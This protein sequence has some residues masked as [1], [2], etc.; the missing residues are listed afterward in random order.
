M[1][2][3]IR[4]LALQDVPLSETLVLRGMVC[5]ILSWMWAHH[6]GLSLRPRSPRTQIFRAAL[7]GLALT[8]FSLSYDWLTASTVAVLSNI[9]VPMLIVLGPVVG[10]TASRKLRGFAALSILFLVWY[11][12]GLEVQKDLWWGLGSLGL[13]SVLLCF[14]FVFIKKSMTEENEA[15]TVWVPALALIAY[16]LIER[17]V[18]AGSPS[19]GSWQG[20]SL[21][22]G[23]LSG[24]GMFGAY[25]ATMRLYEVT[26]LAS[27]EFPT[28]LSSIVIQPL[29]FFLLHEPMQ[30]T[31]LVSS[32]GFVLFT[33]WIVRQQALPATRSLDLPR[34][35]QTLD[36][37]CGAACFESMFRFLKGSSP[38][39][40]FFARELKSL[41]LGYTPPENI[42]ELAR[43]YGLSCEMQ[44]GASL[45]ELR[46]YFDRG[47]VVF[48]TWWDEDAGHYS[49]IKELSQDQIL[50][51]DPW[52]AR[53]GLDHRLPLATFIPHWQARGSRF[54]SVSL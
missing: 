42:V 5:G 44:T 53:E 36:F 26:D 37:T 46:S 31:F 51:M 21:F 50:L 2:I 16:G 47:Q 40:M 41:E 25:V 15:I 54:I 6:R 7:A 24:A 49:L 34:V 8:F 23:V 30:A 48:V 35:A 43:Q 52:L 4:W 38:G 11:V 12:S 10:V 29:E 17:A 33:Y 32:L 1:G 22:V 14:G 9:D 18:G 13:G 39:E 19:T 3:C 45:L 27:A 28:L 20:L